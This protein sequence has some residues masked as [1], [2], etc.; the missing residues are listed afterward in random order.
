ME[1]QK[2]VPGVTP[3]SISKQ[4]HVPFSRISERK[5]ERILD[6]LQAHKELL[7][8]HMDQISL[9][10][11]D[12]PVDELDNTKKKLEEIEQQMG[13]VTA[14][15]AEY[16]SQR[17]R[18]ARGTQFRMSGDVYY[19]DYL[20][21]DKI[22]NAQHLESEK[23]G[24]HP[25]HDEMLFIIV[26]QTY[27][28]WFKQILHE[29]EATISLLNRPMV[30]ENEM[31]RIVHHLER[32]VQIQA[33]LIQQFSI[34][35]TMTPLDFLDFRDF[36]F[37]ASGFQSFQFRLVENLLGMRS[38]QRIEYERA[39]YHTRLSNEHK[40]IAQKAEKGVSLF[41][42]IEKWLERMPFIKFHEF[43]TID[44]YIK[45]ANHMFELDEQTIRDCI[46]DENDRKKELDRL[47]ASQQTFNA[48]F[49]EEAHNEA[50]RKGSRRLSFKATQAALIILL[51]QDEPLF[52]I[53]FRLL[54]ALLDVDEN[55]AG[56]RH[57][58]SMMVGRMIGMKIGT[59]GSSGYWYLKATVERGRIFTDISN[60]STY[61]IPRD[62]IPK[63]PQEVKDALN[64]SYTNIASNSTK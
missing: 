12:F 23:Y 44:I 30:P 28:L 10:P 21:L 38:E 17:K 1:G 45:A 40:L 62:Q 32:V 8:F 59:G 49:N 4:L 34:L 33:V 50:I 46:V 39:A 5:Y 14:K 26:H 25:A 24:T 41:E 3:V 20:E 55:F 11:K 29:I 31:S 64:F 60:L 53:P 42:V 56:W 54:Q 7:Q 15:L 35:E 9:R 63:L 43:D 48:I 19:A 6:G 37:P 18:I 16:A 2:E 27:E 51:Y 22:L 47:H 61:L 36:L 13:D 57:K 52:Q 58:H